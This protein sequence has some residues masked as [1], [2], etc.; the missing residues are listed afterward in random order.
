[1]A[2][3]IKTNST[4]VNQTIVDK[5]VTGGQGYLFGIFNNETI[6]LALT[7]TTTTVNNFSNAALDTDKYYHV[8]FVIDR[9]ANESHIYIN[10]VLESTEDISAITGSLSTSQVFRIGNASPITTGFTYFDGIIGELRLYKEALSTSDMVSLYSSSTPPD[11]TNLELY[12]KLDEGTG[13]PVDSSSNSHTLTLTGATWA[14]D[15][16][17]ADIMANWKNANNDIIKHGAYDVDGVNDYITVSDSASLSF[18]LL[19]FLNGHLL[20]MPQD[21]LLLAR[22]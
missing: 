14:T 10:G 6:V 12:T 11:D 5:R 16:D 4:G 1:L 17:L 7:D 19:V 2:G 21:S 15:K 22:L 8:A 20:T 3:W 13:T 18:H 9:T